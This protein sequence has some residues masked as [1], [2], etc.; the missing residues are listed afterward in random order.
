MATKISELSTT[1]TPS[2]SSTLAIVESSTTKKTTIDDL[3][4]SRL[5]WFDVGHNGADQTSIG[6]SETQL[7]V[8]A[9]DTNQGGYSHL[10]HGVSS[11]DV[12]DNSDSRIKLG[13]LEEGQSIAIRVTGSLTTDTNN[14][15]AVV[16]FKFFDS[17]DSELFSLTTFA[18]FVKTAS[19]G[20][21]IA[22]T[23]SPVWISADLA[24]AGYCKVYTKFDTGLANAVDMGGFAVAV[25]K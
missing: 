10:P 3:L 20:H 17:S 21:K 9:A 1:T 2:S 8:D 23:M 13:W 22:I 6:T 14:T 4:D 7:I 25:L 16:T 5:G 15:G 19:S 24:D 18:I 12:Y 11:S